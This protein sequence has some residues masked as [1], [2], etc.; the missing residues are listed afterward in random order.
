[1]SAV[2]Y[3][4]LVGKYIRMERPATEA[5][6][7]R[8]EPAVVGME[9]TVAYVRDEPGNDV[10]IVTDYGMGYAVRPAEGWRFTIWQDEARARESRI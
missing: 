2:D 4:G 6:R 5:E 8:G 3:A 7:G 9:G 1:V 10:A